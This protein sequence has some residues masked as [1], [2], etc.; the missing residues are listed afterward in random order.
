MKQKF[1][2]GYISAIMDSIATYY[3]KNTKISDKVK[4]RGHLFCPYN[5]F[6]VILYFVF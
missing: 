5:P 2:V 4:K 1:K 3:K 6:Y